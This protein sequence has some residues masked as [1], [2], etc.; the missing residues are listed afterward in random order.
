MEIIVFALIWVCL[1][2]WT[3]VTSIRSGEA[4]FILGSRVTKSENAVSYWCSVTF[5]LLAFGATIYAVAT[6]SMH[7][8]LAK[9]PFGTRGLLPVNTQQW[10]LAAMD[11]FF[12]LTLVYFAWRRV[13]LNRLLREIEAEETRGA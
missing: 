2:G 12:A 8:I 4:P 11:L 7:A 13:R 10:A 1:A 6:L 5:W 9:P 3:F